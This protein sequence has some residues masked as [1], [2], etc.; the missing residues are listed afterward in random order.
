LTSKCHLRILIVA[1]GIVI[2]AMTGQVAL[3]SC[4]AHILKEQQTRLLARL[5][6]GEIEIDE[7]AVVGGCASGAVDSMRVMADRAWRSLVLNVPLV[8]PERAPI[9]IENDI[10]VMALVAKSIGSGA[11]GSVVSCLVVSL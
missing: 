4:L 1:L 5:D 2:L 6:H 11:F 7:V 3:A 10:P 8:L 9:L